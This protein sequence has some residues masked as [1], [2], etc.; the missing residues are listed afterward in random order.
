MGKRWLH[1]KKKLYSGAPKETGRLEDL[2]RR[3]E[4]R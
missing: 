4:D 2:E 1:I 3:E